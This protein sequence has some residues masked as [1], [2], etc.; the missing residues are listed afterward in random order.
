M[1]VRAEA[2]INL[3]SCFAVSRSS[4]LGYTKNT[5]CV[6]T[7]QSHSSAP[8]KNSFQFFNARFSQIL[9]DN[10][11]EKSRIYLQS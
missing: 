4:L 1:R 11:K 8:K 7:D 3:L 6:S 9:G 2:L 5:D 10:R